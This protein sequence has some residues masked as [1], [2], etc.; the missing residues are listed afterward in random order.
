MDMINFSQFFNLS[1]TAP[2]NLQEF[3]P[4]FFN[5]CMTL[6]CVG[7]AFEFLKFVF[8]MCTGKML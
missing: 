8:Q 2:S 6:I 3:I 5:G 4:F 7:G 1:L